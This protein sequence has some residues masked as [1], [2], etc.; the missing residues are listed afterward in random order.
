M[1]RIPLRKFRVEKGLDGFLYYECHYEIE[2]TH[3][4]AY[5]K[6]ELIHD[7]MNYGSVIAEYV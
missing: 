7:G 1:R 4:S 3:Y 6:Y 2:I 5:T